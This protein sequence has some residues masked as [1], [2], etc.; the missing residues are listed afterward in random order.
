MKI[1]LLTLLLLYLTSCNFS[2][3]GNYGDL[4][5]KVQ[6]IDAD[7]TAEFGH[8]PI[9]SSIEWGTGEND[10]NLV[11]TFYEYDMDSTTY[12]ELEQLSYKITERVL[13]QNP[14][15][16]EK[17]FIEVRFTKETDTDETNSFVTF[18]KMKNSLQQQH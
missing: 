16:K 18:R 17:D 12:A 11:V 8:S 13:S 5:D 14:D 15:F 2:D 6:T 7:L 3:T 9:Y 10:N 4:I 1:R